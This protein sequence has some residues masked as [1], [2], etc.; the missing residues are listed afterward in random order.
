V[1]DLEPLQ[2]LLLAVLAG[3]RRDLGAQVLRQ[4]VDAAPVL[5]ALLARVVR[6]VE[7]LEQRADRL[8]ADLR[9]ELRVPFL[10]GLDAQL[11]VLVLVQELLVAQ[12]LA[13]W[14][15]DH[16]ARVVDHLLQVTE[17]HAEEVAHLARQRLEEPDVRHGHGQLDVAHALAADLRE[18]D[19]DAALVADVATEADALELPAVALPVLDGAEDPLAEEAIPLRLERPVVDGLRLGDLAVRPAP[20]LLR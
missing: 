3:L 6:R 16:V 19:L 8:R 12:V 10:A 9:A 15:G 4:P 20:D 11:V 7:L 17:R 18:R 1:D 2:L 14:I 5:V 13:T